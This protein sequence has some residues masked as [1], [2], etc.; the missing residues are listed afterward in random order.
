MLTLQERILR[1]LDKESL[2]EDQGR[3]LVALSGGSD[4]VALTLL[5]NSIQATAR[6]TLAGVVHLNHQMRAAADEDERFCQEF[7]RQLALRFYVDRADVQKQAK[8]EGISI[9]DA[10]HRARYAFFRRVLDKSGADRL[11]TAHTRD[12]QAETHLMRLIR[13][14]GPDG[15]AGIRPRSGQIIRPMLDVSR[16]ELRKFLATGGIKFCEDETNKD[17]SITRNRVRHELLPL[18]KDRFS[19]AIVNVLARDAAIARRD[20]EW[21]DEAANEQRNTIVTEDRQG[22][23]LDVLALGRQPPALARRITKWALERV[24]DRT[25]GFNDIERLLDFSRR[26]VS[27]EAADF[28]GCRVVRDAGRLWI[29]RPRRRRQ[30]HGAAGFAY[31]LVVPG[32]VKVPEAGLVISALPISTDVAL[33]SVLSARG[34]TV[35]VAAGLLSKELVVRSWRPGD[36]VRPLGLG[37]HK[38]LQ[39]F[40]VDR[41]VARRE[42]RKVPIVADKSKGIV[43]VVGH[44]V[45]EDFRVS[46]ETAGML[47]LKAKK[48]G[49]AV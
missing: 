22:L 26:T 5:L 37:G 39:D 3:V 32:E 41:K 45:A 27:V 10:G 9:E 21:L 14:A 36:V 17:L 30:A 25:V 49:G 24:A 16:A 13:G 31:S 7:S 19:P 44:T 28:P 12:D 8:A 29:T 23:S 20:A 47:I 6:F 46:A 15:L 4:S 43:W 40:F 33:P 2:V 35:A 48:V 1:L 42:R 34:S 38:K 18:L 11:A